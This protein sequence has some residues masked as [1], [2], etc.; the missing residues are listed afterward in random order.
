MTNDNGN[1]FYDISGHLILD[2]GKTAFG[3]MIGLDENNRLDGVI[4]DGRLPLHVAVSGAVAVREGLQ[5]VACV[6][7]SS[8]GE[9]YG[10]IAEREMDADKL[11]GRY[12]GVLFLVA[13]RGNGLK[14]DGKSELPVVGSIEFCLT[15]ASMEAERGDL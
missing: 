9:V 2:R 8:N 10:A 5:Q 6:I 3:G 12:H 11:V 4:E 7:P 15:Q 13:D 14:L 1:A